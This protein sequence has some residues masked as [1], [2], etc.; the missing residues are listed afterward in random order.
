[1]LK[2]H[3][4]VASTVRKTYFLS[5]Y[6]DETFYG[7]IDKNGNIVL[8]IAF[9]YM[10]SDGDYI[11]T[12]KEGTTYYFDRKQAII[13]SMGKII[14]PPKY[15]DLGYSSNNGFS[16]K[17]IVVSNDELY[18]VIDFNSDIVLPLLYEQIFIY[19]HN[20][21]YYFA[22]KDKYKNKTGLINEF[23]G[24]RDEEIIIPFE[25]NRI[26]VSEENYN[27]IAVSKNN[28]YGAIDFDNNIIVPIKYMYVSTISE[29]MA[30]VKYV[31]PD[32]ISKYRA[33]SDIKGIRPLE[34]IHTALKGYFDFISIYRN[35]D[36]KYK[37]YTRLELANALS[38]TLARYKFYEQ[39]AVYL[40]DYCNY[41]E[42]CLQIV[43]GYSQDLPGKW[44]YF[45][46][47]G[48]LVIDFIYDDAEPFENGLAVVKFNGKWG[49]INKK[50]E[51]VIPIKYT[52][53][54]RIN[55]YDLFV[56]AKNKRDKKGLVDVNGVEYFTND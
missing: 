36:Y 15:R 31:E 1:V 6:R 33:S 4:L 55:G 35:P 41:E 38:D 10:S 26:S 9:G 25:Y 48:E 43:I 20:N 16:K 37:E 2:S 39:N 12:D 53:L 8:P 47:K 3:L 19:Q 49:A 21:K 7:I 28:R 13:S 23:V 52:E 34:N 17:Y 51:I 50:G 24:N 56:V 40:R 14:I 44:G 32:T 45:N 46:D 27:W 5:E 18:G 11:R 54:E 30:N 22:V 42:F 29:G